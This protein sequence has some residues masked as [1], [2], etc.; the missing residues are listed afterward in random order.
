MQNRTSDNMQRDFYVA[1]RQ[2][3]FPVQE[4]EPFSDE[5]SEE[6]YKSFGI[7]H[8][9]SHFN[10]HFDIKGNPIGKG[11]FGTVL[12]V[13]INKFL[14]INSISIFKLFFKATKKS[15]QEKYAIKQILIDMARK[16]KVERV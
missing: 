12:M 6:L 2:M 5:E 7:R 1:E 4:S 10:K 16:D 14:F 15:D 13:K 3:S 9:N 11:S 8:Q